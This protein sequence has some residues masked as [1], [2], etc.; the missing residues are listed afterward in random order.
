MGIALL[1]GYRDVASGRDCV[2]LI[3]R[4][5]GVAASW[6]QLFLVLGSDP[7]E[8]WGWG[9]CVYSVFPRRIRKFHPRD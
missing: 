8:S 6:G 7:S 2:E 3:P 9:R 5:T 1:S 4:V